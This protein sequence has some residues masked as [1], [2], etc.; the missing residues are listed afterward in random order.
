MSIPIKVIPKQNLSPKSSL[1]LEA[2]DWKALDTIDEWSHFS[3]NTDKDHT[4]WESHI[5]I[6]GMHC[7][8]C[9]FKVENALKPLSGVIEAT[10]NA[11]SG[12]AKI[13][14]QSNLIKPSQW[15]SGIY[16][17]GYQAFPASD[18]LHQDERKKNQRQALWRLLV[19][20][21]CMMQVMMFSVPTYMAIPGEMTSNMKGLMEWASWVI[22]L[23]VILFSCGPFFKSA[24]NDLRTKQISMDMPVSLGILIMFI[25]STA[26]TFDP[27]G[28]L[29]KEVYFDSLTMF[30]FFLLTGR[31]IEL[32]M[33]DKT[34]GALDVLMRRMPRM[35][36]R[37]NPDGSIEKIPVT[38]LQIG[39]T[40]EVKAGEA[41]PADG[42]IILGSTNADEALLTG[43]SAA[44]RKSIHA[45]V[46]AGSFNLTNPVH[47]RVELVG[48]ETRYAKIVHLMEKA[49]TDKPRLALMADRIAKHFLWIVILLALSVGIY[50]WQFDHA[51]AIVA[52]VA[53]LIVTC[54]CA[55]SLATPAAMLSM[56][57]F[58]ARQGILVQKMQAL[59]AL[60]QINTVVF[61]KTGTLTNDQIFIE[62]IFT[63]KK[64][65]QKEAL[66]IAASISTSSL[67]PV[68]KAFI[69]A[70]DT[71]LSLKIE[72]LEEVSGGGLLAKTSLGVFKLG[73]LTFCGLNGNEFDH[74]KEEQLQVHLMQDDYWIA[75]FMMTESIKED[76]FQ[77]IAALKDQHLNIEILS[78]DKLSSV[79]RVAD[80][81]TIQNIKGQ[82]SPE[83]KLRHIQWL[84]SQ[85]SKVLMV[86]DGLNDG[87]VLAFAHASIALGQG[88]PLSQAQSDF[89]ILKGELR[90][91][92]KL[93]EEAKRTMKIIK[94]NLLWAALYNL[95]CI[96]LAVMGFLPAWL[97]GLG[98]AL[99]SLFV[100]LNAARLAF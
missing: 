7:A 17:A 2:S 78:G 29:G 40:L 14:W 65:T 97:A 61:D 53:V 39:D 62:K 60:T 3:Q 46:I 42:E 69:N 9:A 36:N 98:M 23:P 4:R 99:S 52:A 15:A 86:G 20:G 49:S 84:Q 67:H 64:I 25:V 66:V 30:V 11:T 55:L 47:M 44:V 24:L 48:Q 50:F 27:Y 12:H 93:I 6:E 82:C 75:S 21:F 13:I 77:S 10:V 87:P 74:L 76:A 95:I 1:S 38:L 43:E 73:S 37:V 80:Q 58:L 90:L 5:V 54:P 85:Q 34:A 92:P 100:I 28:L 70:S 88:A 72:K 16:K 79:K 96:P 91:I 68:S 57:G 83:D 35:V 56:S 31:W 33:R 19:A 18:L 89:I 81:L 22:T 41:F 63:N 26:A 51:K 32:K 45:Q 8:A 94:Q 71:D 59:E